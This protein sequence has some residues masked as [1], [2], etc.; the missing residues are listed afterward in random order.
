[1]SVHNIFNADIHHLAE[2][3]STM[4]EARALARSGAGLG[5]VVVADFQNKGRG[6]T[7]ER[8]W[9]SEP[10]QNLL[11][12]VIFRYNSIVD[13]PP[14]FTLQTGLAAAR[15]IE[16]TESRLVGRV[17]VKWPN[18]VMING[19]KAAGI[20]VESDGAYVLAGIGVNVFQ[21]RFASTA[22]ATSIVNELA[23]APQNNAV[24]WDD[25]LRFMLLEKILVRLYYDI[26][27]DTSW[28]AAL[29]KKLYMKGERVC[30]FEGA[31]GS[32]KAVYGAIAGLDPSGALLLD[33]GGGL[34]VQKFVTGE[35]SPAPDS[36]V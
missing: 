34:G 18:D 13:I 6:R 21:T 31:A 26:K 9:E 3:G 17:T 22:W 33:C 32:G 7:A 2:C 16:D 11:F 8:V 28:I 1:M 24:E 35:L 14:A 4:D 36:G 25:S 10:K 12:T 30:F 5:T 20:L 23:A 29:E 27:T 19:R 15:A